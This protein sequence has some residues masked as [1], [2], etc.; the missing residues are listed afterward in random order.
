MLKLMHCIAS[1]KSAGKR[2][3]GGDTE[4]TGTARK[5]AKTNASLDEDDS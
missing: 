1:T 5:R 2:K 3:A 4:Q